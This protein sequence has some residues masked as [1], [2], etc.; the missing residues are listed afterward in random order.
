[1]NL[2]DF[3]R[4]LSEGGGAK[5]VVSGPTFVITFA[6]NEGKEYPIDPVPAGPT[7]V[8]RHAAL[9]HRDSGQMV[10]SCTSD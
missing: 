2:Q 8:E 1:M 10:Q 3:Y 5:V 9:G 6:N 7:I 4:T